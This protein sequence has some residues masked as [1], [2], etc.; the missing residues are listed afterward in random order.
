MKR[1]ALYVR[2]ST[3]EQKK[4]G[5]SVDS[6]IVALKEFCKSNGY[7]IAN[8]YNDAGI[9][10]RKKYTNRPA[11]LS[12]INDCEA[13]KIDII[14]FT[15][16]DR[17]FRSVGD[18]YEV[19]GHLDACKV[20][21]RAI[22]EDYETETSSGVFKVNIMLSVAQSEAD[23][24]SER[25]RST[26]D[27]KRAKGDYI[28]T[29]PLGYKREN[30]RLVKDP[31]TSAC[32]EA[33]F[34]TYARTHSSASCIKK[35]LEYGVNLSI[36]GTRRMLISETYC[37]NAYGFPCEPY[38]TR[39]QHERIVEIRK[40][41]TRAPKMNHTYLFSGLCVC[42]QCHGHMRVFYTPCNGIYYNNYC[43]PGT[44]NTI[45]HPFISISERKIEKYLLTN[46][47]PLLSQYNGLYDADFINSDYEIIER[48]KASLRQ[49]LERVGTRFEIGDITAEEYK[50]KRRLLLEEIASL[51]APLNS[52]NITIPDNWKET[53]D[54]LDALHK[55]EFWFS[56]IQKIEIAPDSD[57]K[58]FFT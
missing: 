12:L 2:V 41:N 35:A 13:G 21:W 15:K 54:S 47:E 57:P 30:N 10:A 9:S 31:E 43:C 56:I 25:I 5:L 38:I 51:P 33:I 27:Y 14:I 39:E 8:V 42:P 23:R 3:Q 49:R 11:L 58:I 28:G 44:Y 36:S 37:G 18:Y 52:R 17:W 34:E 19:Q 55:R 45:K 7:A 26:F 48:K 22:W 24:T 50:E 53:Y 20:P 29:A 46:L 4:H 16:L 32:V 6:Q 1:A 40:S